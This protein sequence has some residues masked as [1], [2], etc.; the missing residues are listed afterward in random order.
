MKYLK[1]I[2]AFTSLAAI[3]MAFTLAGTMN[4]SAAGAVGQT[5][6]GTEQPGDQVDNDQEK[7][8]N[9][10]NDGDTDEDQ[11]QDGDQDQDGE[12][13][14]MDDAENDDDSDD[15]EDGVDERHKYDSYFE[16]VSLTSSIRKAVGTQQQLTLSNMTLEKEK[17]SCTFTST[18]P[19]K[20]S[21]SNEG[22]VTMKAAGTVTVAAVIICDNGAVYTYTCNVKVTNPKFS[23][24]KY[25]IKKNGTVTIK[26]TGGSTSKYTIV[27]DNKSVIS[28]VSANSTKVKGLQNGKSKVSVT[29]DGKTISC[30]V[31][32]SA[33]K[34]N[35]T[36]LYI[37][38]GKSVQLKVSG[39]SKATN[40][41][42][43]S[44]NKSVATVSKTGK[45]T[46]KKYGSCIITVTVD[47]KQLQCYV[48]SSNKK[49]INTIK[50]AYKRIGYKYSQARRMQKNYYDCSS[51][52]WRCYSKNGVKFGA[53]SYAPTAAGEAYNMVKTKKALYYKGVTSDKLLP[54]DVL[55][56]KNKTKNGRYK[57]IGHVVMYI[58]NG[59]I[60]HSTPP[61][62]RIDSYTRY[63]YS[64]SNP[65]VL[66]TR[67]T[68]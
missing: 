62:V 55:F 39:H 66:I 8:N 4:A 32:V 34:L 38:K 10:G 43:T 49:V 14:D 44:S 23:S 22:L 36:D 59:R 12:P 7:D 52:V 35:Y 33:P 68:K 25:F 2:I 3:V 29:M 1:R 16:T 37:V 42:Y 57:N 13:G 63:L 56:V 30:Y 58:G 31:Y 64:K 54:G 11:N 21:V 28:Q 19:K 20:A 5:E 9:Q 65:Y 61:K 50:E 17:Y 24:D 6:N 45:I 41:T 48:A 27:V 40:V 60:I 15:V 51:F 47:G 67:P 53:K 18:D 26:V 46:T